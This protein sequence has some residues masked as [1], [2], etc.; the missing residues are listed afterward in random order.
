MLQVFMDKVHH[1]CTAISPKYVDRPTKLIDG[2]ADI[3]SLPSHPIIR[4]GLRYD[5]PT[6]DTLI[7]GDVIE[8]EG[9]PEIYVVYPTSSLESR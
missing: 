7:S 2:W 8:L 4:N 1:P 3:H 6:S 9:F 5:A